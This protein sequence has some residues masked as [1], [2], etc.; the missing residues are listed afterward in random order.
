MRKFAIENLGCA[1]NQVDAEVLISNLEKDDWAYTEDAA[2]ASLIIVNSCG[3]IQPAKEEAI[4]VSLNLKQRHPDKKILLAGCFAQR[5]GQT[6]KEGLPEVDGFFGNKALSRI[7]SAAEAVMEGHRP[8]ILPRA[9]QRVETEEVRRER[10]LSFPNSAFVKISEGCSHNCSFCAIP[11]IRGPLKSRP[12]ETVIREIQGL[13][14][15]GFREFNLVG[16]DLGSFGKDRGKKEFD[17]LLS[18]IGEIE[19]DFWIRLLY[20]HPDHFPLEIIERIH[21]DSRV[22]PYFDIPFQHASPTIL[23]KM[24]RKGNGETHLAL[25]QRLRDELPGSVI[26]S[27]FLVGFPGETSKDFAL[28]KDFQD[29]ARLDWLG[30]FG[31]SREEDTAAARLQGNFS[32]RIRGKRREKYR[33]LLMQRQTAITEERMERFVGQ[34]MRILIEEPVEGESLYMGRAYL[35]A[36]EVDGLT[37]VDARGLSPGEMVRVRIKRRNGLDLEAVPV[38]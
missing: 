1:K 19:G 4:Q 25:I 38:K 2:E 5:Y 37:L 13:L 7:G 6:L 21:R 28:L 18:R 8:V 31:Y 35:Q 32:Y 34:E 23:E 11:L 10:I 16:Q 14:N 22:L 29:R 27:T 26:R 17:R 24:G 20:L 30:I 9:N 36:P 3:F 15:R 33:D 12:V